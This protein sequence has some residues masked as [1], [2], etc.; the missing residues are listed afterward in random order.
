SSLRPAGIVAFTSTRCYGQMRL[1]PLRIQAITTA[2]QDGLERAGLHFGCETTLADADCT[3]TALAEWAAQNKVRH[4]AAMAPTTGPVADVLPRL[5]VLLDQAG[6][7][8][9]LVRR[10]WDAALFPLA[11]AGFFP[12]W[13]KTRVQLMRGWIPGG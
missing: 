2:L 9:H 11:K 4:L 5:R 1:S 8:L 6:I 3:A 13:E 12:F 7:V 10:P